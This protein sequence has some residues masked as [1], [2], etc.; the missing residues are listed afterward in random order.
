MIF[1][2]YIP[3]RTI[4][5]CAC[6][7]LLI[8]IGCSTSK[9]VFVLDDMEP[10][11]RSVD[12]V[13]EQLPDYRENLQTISGSGRA[14]VS[15]PGGNERVTVRFQSNR[16]ESLLNVRNSLGIEGGQIYV[17]RDS[18]LIY[19]RI[20]KFAEKVAVRE[21]KLT[22][23]G[24]IASMN[25]LDL[26][27][28]TLDSS[29]VTQVYEDNDHVALVLTDQSYVVILKNSYHIKEVV[30]ANP[31]EAPF[32]RIEYDGYAEI[33]GFILPR[34]ITIFSSNGQSRAALLVQNLELNTELPDLTITIPDDIPIYR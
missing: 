23:V 34:R 18:L 22:S 6:T 3:V 21:G 20:D 19:N 32:S 11:A 28:Y 5:I 27:N 33:N 12:D 31:I 14:I 30:R 1:S 17:D 7:A 13:L 16:N 25:I 9:E 26:F 24:S 15:E 8:L 4:V 10:S 2:G 29:D